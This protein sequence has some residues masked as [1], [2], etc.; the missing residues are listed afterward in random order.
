M[1]ETYEIVSDFFF[2][3]QSYLLELLD[4]FCDTIAL[5]KLISSLTG[6]NMFYLKMLF[7]QMKPLSFM[8][9]SVG[10]TLILVRRS[11]L[12]HLGVS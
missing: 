3:K 2:Q 7:I 4:C 11:L 12:H 10:L 8:V 5:V 9:Q 6:E 1:K